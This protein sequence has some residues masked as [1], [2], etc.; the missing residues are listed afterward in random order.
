MKTLNHSPILI[1]TKGNSPLP[2]AGN[3]KPVI[4]AQGKQPPSKEKNLY[5]ICSLIPAQGN[6]PLPKKE[7]CKPVQYNY[8]A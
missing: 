4:L 8:P 7:T 2:K 6:S 1:L 3:P 5:Q